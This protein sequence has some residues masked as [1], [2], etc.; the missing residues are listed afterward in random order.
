ML[1][2]REKSDGLTDVQNSPAGIEHSLDDPILT[3][4]LAIQPPIVERL[5]EEDVKLLDLSGAVVDGDEAGRV[6]TTGGE[7]S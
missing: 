3:L 1:S 2:V 4:W 5:G 7:R 6:A